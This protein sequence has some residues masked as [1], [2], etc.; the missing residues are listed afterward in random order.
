M[1]N[2]G[3]NFWFL[4]EI[5]YVKWCSAGEHRWKDVLVSKHVNRCVIKKYKYG[6]TDSG[7]WS[8]GLLCFSSLFSNDT[9]VL[10]R[11]TLSC[12]A[13]LVGDASQRN[14]PKN[15]LWSPCCFL[16][17]P[18]PQVGWWALCFCFCFVFFRIELP[19]LVHVWWLP[20]GLDCSWCFVFGVCYWTERLISWQWR[21]DLPPK[22]YF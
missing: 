7:S 21:L 14:L 16:L 3:G 6:T 1:G 12:W 18:R 2:W 22:K 4:W 5:S 10:V 20:S 17:L 9:H 19:L 15:F 11:L 13:P 8:I